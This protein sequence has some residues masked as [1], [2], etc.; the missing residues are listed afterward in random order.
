MIDLLCSSIQRPRKHSNFI[1]YTVIMTLILTL[2]LNTHLLITTE[3]PNTS[4]VEDLS[5]K[6]PLSQYEQVDANSPLLNS[7]EG[8]TT[9][10]SYL[11]KKT[12][13]RPINSLSATETILNDDIVY[14]SS[15]GLIVEDIVLNDQRLV[16]LN[17]SDTI[18]R[19]VTVNTS[20]WGIILEECQ[21]IL[22]ENCTV[23]DGIA[24]TEITNL[25][26]QGCTVSDS[27]WYFG[28]I[29][30]QRC[31]DVVIR[32][33]TLL[34]TIVTVTSTENINITGN[35][36][37]IGKIK[38][39]RCNG[40]VI[41][42][43][44]MNPSEGGIY[45]L[46]TD[47][48]AITNNTIDSYQGT[49]SIQFTSSTSISIEDNNL[50]RAYSTTVDIYRCSLLNITENDID[51]AGVGLSVI[52]TNSC[53]ITDNRLSLDFL[54]SKNLINSTG[55]ALH[56]G[57]DSKFLSKNIEI[58]GNRY[59]NIT[60]NFSYLSGEITHGPG[61]LY[62][63]DNYLDGM[64]FDGI[65]GVITTTTT[66]TITTTNTTVTSSTTSETIAI[67]VIPFLLTFAG[68]TLYVMIKRRGKKQSQ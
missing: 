3:Q 36:V 32:N 51:M 59:W 52:S 6:S 67:P 27:E 33:N 38:I 8:K 50:S 28:D 47:N 41:N 62:V 2:V 16:L 64:L 22:V 55:F 18:I 23:I 56:F 42:N 13:S 19:N 46:E 11:A 21:D 65:P 1:E 58:T 4:I 20:S 7:K 31:S 29:G 12:S 63:H 61:G 48:I 57:N 68:N 40:V 9:I 60:K 37:Q 10:N 45:V 30:V 5:I 44:M 34:S 53:I 24:A 26:I 25:T 14:N 39:E 54:F 66:T 17:C 43:N 35:N 15:T 49:Y